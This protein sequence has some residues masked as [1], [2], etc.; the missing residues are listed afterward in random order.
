MKRK[1]LS[2]LL[3]ILMSMMSVD[4]FATDFS[5]RALG[6]SYVN[7]KTAVEVTAFYPSQ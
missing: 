6:Y 4:A 1:K 5:V 7:N 3:A 2:F